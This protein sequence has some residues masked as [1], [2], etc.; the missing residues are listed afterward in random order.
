M[1]ELRDFCGGH[2][3]P[4][5][6]SDADRAQASIRGETSLALPIFLLI[7]LTN[8][9]HFAEMMINIAFEPSLPAP[10]SMRCL[11]YGDPVAH[12]VSWAHFDRILSGGFQHEATKRTAN[13]STRVHSYCSQN[14]CQPVQAKYPTMW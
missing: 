12:K 14:I 2:G 3:T 1:V 13:I 8:T 7:L 9:S 6:C 11:L 5:P 4:K 10:H